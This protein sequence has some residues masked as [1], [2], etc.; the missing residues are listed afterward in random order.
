MLTTG[1]TFLDEII[2]RDDIVEFFSTD[3]DLLRIFYHRVI[4]ISAPVYVVVVSERG[5]LDPYLIGRFQNVFDNHAEVYIRRAF[6]AED[7]PIT[8]DS[9]G[10]N[11]LI[12]IDPYHHRKNYT[13][14]VLSLRKV[15]GRK[16]LFSFMD[17]ERE[18]SIF[19]SHT[20]HSMIKLVKSARGFKFVIVKSVTSREIEIP[21]YLLDLYGKVNDD[22]GL[23][24]YMV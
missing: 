12:V 24:K 8:I 22:G 9:M 6:K 7:V 15:R 20:S 1:F 18:G 23:L 11:D 14:I 3:Y 10:D 17:R 19:G 2:K 13:K 4:A 16:F 21:S 5:G